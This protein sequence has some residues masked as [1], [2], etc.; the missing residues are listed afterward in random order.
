MTSVAKTWRATPIFLAFLC[1]GFGDAVGPFV[2]LA[3]E[4]FSLS[5]LEAQLIAFAGF[6]MF[7]FLSVPMG[8]FQDRRGKKYTLILGLF[9]ALA[10]LII[11]VIGGLQS[12]LL[13]L[14]TVL[15]LGAGATILQV[16]GNPIMREVSPEGKYA[17]N[18]ALGQFVKAIGSLAGPLLV[19]A[20]ARWWGMDWSILFPVFST[21]LLVTII[22]TLFTPI[23]EMRHANAS[24]ASFSSCL[25]LL[26]DKSVTMMVLGIFLYVGAEVCM[27]SGIP[28]YLNSEFGID[29]SSIG[30]GGV[31][32][33]FVSIM[34][35]RFLGSLILNWISAR[36]FLLITVLVSIIGIL[37][38]FSGNQ[39]VGIA[40][41]VVIGLGFA[42]IF[43]LIFSIAIDAMPERSN[44]LSGL[45]IMAIVGGA[46][47]PPVMGLVAD[48][49]SVLIGFVVPLG[50]ALY[51]LWVALRTLKTT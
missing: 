5:N 14:L 47:M 45:M 22:I 27:S 8:V 1:M 31:G 33:F 38:L 32:L 28:I 40:S 12:Y 30:I 26:S 19:M 11:P 46:V 25:K 37:G 9:I 49:S 44:E 29:I 17:R 2:G 21:V 23:R 43:P 41:F 7:F 34:T 51:I 50:C 4:T 16:A 24:T 13:F 35:G 10:G 20:A 3:K 42:N 15:L 6:I 36:R 48:H 18:L 39:I